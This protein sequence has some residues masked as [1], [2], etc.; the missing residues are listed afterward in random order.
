MSRIHLLFIISTLF[1]VLPLN[2][3]PIEDYRISV[4]PSSKFI[5]NL[6]RN[7]DKIY[8][9]SPWNSASSSTCPTSLQH[10]GAHVDF[11]Y[12]TGLELV[13]TPENTVVI[14]APVAGTLSMPVD[15]DTGTFTT[16]ANNT[17][18]YVG[19]VRPGLSFMIRDFASATASTGELISYNFII[20]L[21]PQVTPDN[22]RTEDVICD[23]IVLEQGIGDGVA[24]VQGQK[25][26][27]MP[28][29]SD[30]NGT[31]SGNYRPHIHFNITSQSTLNVAGTSSPHSGN[32]SS[33]CP[34][35]FGKG[36]R[37]AFVSF[38]QPYTSPSSPDQCPERNP[39][40]HP[41]RAFCFS[42][43]FDNS[44]TPPVDSN[45]VYGPNL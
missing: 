8:Q 10:H 41:S 21:E 4:S 30:P 27:T 43:D 2:A 38:F 7:Q 6:H 25:L 20:G 16:A 1:Y 15:G 33:M 17:C 36:I 42:T 23:N 39:N 22:V 44:S 45:P 37:R 28:I 32:V 24:V 11:N 34:D 31:T 14:R 3:Q 9:T 29:Y 12:S 26:A 5:I 35:V 40:I 19:G 18:G 13:E